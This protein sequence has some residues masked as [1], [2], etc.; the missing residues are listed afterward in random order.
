MGMTFATA[1]PMSLTQNS[2]FVYVLAFVFVYQYGC[3][4][5]SVCLCVSL[6]VSL[7]VC[8]SVCVRMA[9]MHIL[10]SC[11]QTRKPGAPVLQ[12]KL[13]GEV[14]QCFLSECSAE[15]GRTRFQS[16][17][18]NLMDEGRKVGC[19]NYYFY[20]YTYVYVYVCV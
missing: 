7:Y 12:G 1:I 6:H 10:T 2:V 19:V 5:V 8:A 3:V 18:D 9:S 4:Y 13:R 14:A 16:K 15:G 20:L 11:S 17:E